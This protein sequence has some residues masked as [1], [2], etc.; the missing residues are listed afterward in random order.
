MWNRC[1]LRWP[2]WCRS[3]TW[4]TAVADIY[5]YSEWWWSLVSKL[6]V[7]RSINIWPTPYN[8]ILPYSNQQYSYSNY[9]PLSCLLGTR[10]RNHGLV[11]TSKPHSWLWHHRR[12]HCYATHKFEFLA[13]SPMH[14]VIDSVNRWEYQCVARNPFQ[15][16]NNICYFIHIFCNLNTFP[17]II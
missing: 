1:H 3:L 11:C 15:F 17:V 16:N 8:I 6:Q 12:L 2:R 4:V 13:Y 5:I 9:K 14:V 10:T 7:P